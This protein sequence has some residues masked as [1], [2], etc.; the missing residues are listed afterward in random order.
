MSEVFSEHFNSGSFISSLDS[1][2]SIDS[3][4]DDLINYQDELFDQLRIWQDFNSDGISNTGELST[5][6]EVGIESIS[7]L[8]EIMEDEIEGNTINAKGSYLDSDGVT[9]EFV[10]AI[11]SAEELTENQEND[12]FYEDE[13]ILGNNSFESFEKFH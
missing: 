1:L 2:N 9:R 4:N 10:Q 6:N 8:A 11:F 5:L 7:L 3:N 12:S 13:L